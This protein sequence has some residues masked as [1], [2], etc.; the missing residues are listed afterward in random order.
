[1]KKVKLSSLNQQII[2]GYNIHRVK[3]EIKTPYYYKMITVKSMDKG[4]FM[5]WELNEAFLTKKASPEHLTQEGD[6]IIKILSPI[7]FLYITKEMEGILVPVNF[8]ILRLTDTSIS[9]SYLS[10]YLNKQ[11]SYLDS[12]CVGS[13]NMKKISAR[14]LEDIEILIP[15]LDK[16]KT[17][18]KVIELRQKEVELY[19]LKQRFYESAL[20]KLFSEV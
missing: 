20:H 4:N 9:N 1:M 10:V 3:S 16:Q 12:L 15:N 5:P 2:S 7:E 18:E 11:S 8:Y 17:I 13:S 19:E 6:I 14:Q